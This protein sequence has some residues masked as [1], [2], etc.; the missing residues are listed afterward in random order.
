GLA[1]VDGVPGGDEGDGPGQGHVEPGDEL[2]QADDPERECSAAGAPLPPAPWSCCTWTPASTAV[3]RAA[4]E[5][6][7]GEGLG[8]PLQGMGGADVIVSVPTMRAAP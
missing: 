7:V 1:E 3:G 8:Q 6:I 4:H 2:D 5:V